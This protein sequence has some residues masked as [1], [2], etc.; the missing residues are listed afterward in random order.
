VRVQLGV[1]VD[2]GR[3][4]GGHDARLVLSDGTALRNVGV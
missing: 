1:A 2:G 3:A 4:A